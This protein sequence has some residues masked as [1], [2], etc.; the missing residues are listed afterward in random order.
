VLFVLTMA[1]NLAARLL[2]VATS[3]KASAL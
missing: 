2:V 3:R 1:I